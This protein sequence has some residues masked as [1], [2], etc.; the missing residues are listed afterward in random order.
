MVKQF[1]L[2]LIGRH[3][4]ISNEKI[5]SIDGKLSFPKYERLQKEVNSHY[6][7][8]EIYHI[9]YVPEEKKKDKNVH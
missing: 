1:R 4:R 9:K 2:V 6:Q 7:K 3:W 8:C 5:F